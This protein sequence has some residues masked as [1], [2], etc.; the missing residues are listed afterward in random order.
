MSL[1]SPDRTESVSEPE[2]QPG[3][4]NRILNWISERRWLLAS[5]LV[6]LMM[7][8]SEAQRAESFAMRQNRQVI[9]GMSR[10][11]RERLRHNFDKF[12]GLS[13]KEVEQVRS[14]H[15]VIS[16]EPALERTLS[17]FHSWLASLTFEQRERIRRQPDPARRLEMI[18]S[19]IPGHPMPDIFESTPSRTQFSNLRLDG[20]EFER[21]MRAAAS[22]VGMPTKPATPTPRGVLEYHTRVLSAVMDRILPGWQKQLERPGNRPRP[23]FP[24]SLRIAVLESLTD[25]DLKRMAGERPELQQNIMAMMLLAR[26]L[27]D[28][29]RRLAKTLKPTEDELLEV[30]LTLPEVRRKAL[31]E[32]PQDFYDRILTQMWVTR[33]IE[34]DAGK[35]LSKLA[36]LFERLMNRSPN[37]GFR[38]ND[39]VNRIKRENGALRTDRTD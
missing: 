12:Q 29:T 28:E 2:Q 31:D 27:L 9:E 19:F 23:V 3:R 35:N 33:Q 39:T 24:D 32:M 34:P 16:K 5:A 8:R 4:S 15:A 26:G 17:Q 18:R 11:E 30:Y 38:K 21:M 25:P 22:W 20:E 14:I 10:V 37:G 13:S 7:V 6:V 1:P 36:S